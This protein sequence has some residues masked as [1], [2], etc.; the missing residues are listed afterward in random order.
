M[1]QNKSYRIHTEIGKDH[2]VNVPLNQDMS[3][4]EI[5]S[6]KLRQ[7]NVYKLHTSNYG[8]L[9]GRV[10]ANDAFGVQNAKISIFVELDDADKQNS[11]I[12]N[13]YPYTSIST[14]DNNDIRYNLLPDSNNDKCYRVIGTFPNKRLV[15]DDNTE[16]QIFDKYWKF[17]TVTNKSGDY[18][19][20]G[21]PTGQTTVHVDLDISD[22]GVLSQKPHDLLYK[23]Y[24]ISQFDSPTQFKEGTNLNNLTQ[25]F[26]QDSS[27]YVYPFWGDSDVNEI[28]ITR[29]DVQ[30]QYK[31]E[32]T[33]VF[34][35]SLISDS[36]E[37]FV[38]HNCNPS[39]ENG[40]NS[41][42]VASEGTIEMIRKTVDGFVEEYQIQGNRLINGDGVWCYQIPMN[43]DYI[44][45]D[46][47]GN[48]IPVENSS[49]GIP[50]RARVRFRISI[51]E[52]TSTGISRHRAKYLVPNNPKLKDESITLAT[53]NEYNDNLDLE[54]YYRFGTATPE[55]CYRDLYWNKVY[56][57]K[58]YI[59]RLQRSNDIR[60][61]R[62]TGI[63][64]TNYS[65]NI[66]PFPYN[67]I[68]VR[69]PFS[70]RFMCVLSKI[71]IDIIAFLNTTFISVWD[72]LIDLLA[73]GLNFSILGVHPLGWLARL[74]RKL[75]IPCV[76]FPMEDDESSCDNV[77]YAPGCKGAAKDATGDNVDASLNSLGQ[78][79]EQALAQEDEVV[80][81]DFY[82]DWVNG[83]LY[84]PLWFWKK[85]KKKT[86]FFGL[87]SKSAVN[88]YCNCDLNES[89]YL[90]W[91]CTNTRDGNGTSSDNVEYDSH[92]DETH[93]AAINL[94]RGIIKSIN[95]LEGV[96]IYYYS[97]GVEADNYYRLFS[98]DI[99]LLGS[100]NDCDIDGI[101][102]M[103]INLPTTTHNNMPFAREEYNKCSNT[104][105][106][107]SIEA[108]TGMDIWAHDN[109]NQSKASYGNGY[110]LDIGC[111]TIK[112]FTKTCI[113]VERLCELGVSLDME[114]IT[115]NLSSNGYVSGIS[116][117]DGMITR[118]ELVDNDTRAMFATLNHN[119]LN[120]V[121]I[122]KKTGYKKYDLKYLYPTDFDASL[123]NSAKEYTKNLTYQSQDLYNSFYNMFR[124]GTNEG[125][126]S[127]RIYE[128][129]SS[130]F[131]LYNNSYYFY[132][133]VKEGSTALD[134][135]KSQ[136][137]ASCVSNEIKPFTVIPSTSAASTCVYDDNG[138][139]KDENNL[140]SVQ[141]QI[142]G[143]I[144]PY[145]YTITNSGDEILLENI[146][147]SNK[148]LLF[149]HYF[150][151]N[152]D[153]CYNGSG[154]QIPIVNDT[155]TISITDNKGTTVVTEFIVIN[156]SIDLDIQSF[157]LGTR[158]N[159]ISDGQKLCNDNSPYQ[160]GNIKIYGSTIDGKY[161]SITNGSFSGNNG[162]Y[163]LTTVNG[164]IDISITPLPTDT[165]NVAT[166]NDCCCGSN[167]S[168]YYDNIEQCYELDV[169]YPISYNVTATLLCNGVSTNNQSSYV[170]DI[171]NGDIFMMYINDMPFDFVSG[172][173]Y[174]QQ[175][176]SPT[177]YDKWLLMDKISNYTMNNNENDILTN[178]YKWSQWI[179]VDYSAN[180]ATN[181]SGLTKNTIV[182]EVKF[183]LNTL[184]NICNGAYL[185]NN[186]YNS[187]DI[188]YTGGKTPILLQ[189][190]YPMYDSYDNEI[191]NFYNPLRKYQ[192]V[193]NNNTIES[194]ILIPNI[195]ALNYKYYTG[196][197]WT[198]LLKSDSNLSLNLIIDKNK[199][200][201]QGNY[202]S[203]FTNNAGL[204]NCSTIDTSYK[205]HISIP[206]KTDT[207]PF[208]EHCITGVT[209]GLLIDN[210]STITQSSTPYFKTMFVDRRFDYD[211]IVFTSCNDMPGLKYLSSNNQL[212]WKKSKI[213][214]VTY[215]GIELAY[216]SNKNII[217]NS[218]STMSQNNYEY[219]Y[220]LNGS[221]SGCVITT[222]NDINK[223]FY[224]TLLNGID[225][226]NLYQTTENKNTSLSPITINNTTILNCIPKETYS[227]SVVYPKIRTMDL[228]NLPYN[229]GRI[230]FSSTA[231]SYSMECKSDI[232]GNISAATTQGDTIGFSV[233]DGRNITF[234]ADKLTDAAM[235][236]YKYKSDDTPIYSGWVDIHYSYD[237]NGYY[238]PTEIQSFIKIN[239]D[240]GES[241]HTVRSKIPVFLPFDDEAENM[242]YKLKSLDTIKSNVTINGREKNNSIDYILYGGINFTSD[243]WVNKDNVYA[244][245]TVSFLAPK[246]IWV[247]SLY[248]YAVWPAMRY[249]SY[250]SYGE[251]YYYYTNRTT[252]T[253]NMCLIPVDN[254]RSAR[255][256]VNSG[257]CYF[258]DWEY[259]Y[260]VEVVD[261][262][263]GQV[264]NS[265][266]SAIT[267]GIM[268]ST[269]FWRPKNGNVNHNENEGDSQAISLQKNSD[270]TAFYDCFAIIIDSQY[271][272][273]NDNGLTSSIRSINCSNVFDVRKIKLTLISMTDN[274]TDCNFSF[275]LYYGNNTSFLDVNTLSSI[276]YVRRSTASTQND[277][278]AAWS[279]DIN[280]NTDNSITLSG[281]IG[282]CSIAKLREKNAI[283]GLWIKVTGGLKWCL[284][285]KIK[286]DS[287]A[288]DP[289]G[290]NEEFTNISD[291]A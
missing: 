116:Q 110:F 134:K 178:T 69:L 50:T 142:N 174:S 203:M 265:Y 57:V 7:T 247:A 109:S 104:S 88:T 171:D 32:P 135:F 123:K 122:D 229:N 117:S 268:S 170:L 98:T 172:T 75:E 275:K 56:T 93:A 81:L 206:Y 33:C 221:N 71:I 9:V 241:K 43:L 68:R 22:C 188:A 85:A 34:M 249:G 24:T 217:Y 82:N 150:D 48:I 191:N 154:K 95:N 246:M 163:K 227:T 38:G 283:I 51:D 19:I 278:N 121:I 18:C 5:L 143:A 179:G 94:K 201:L 286:S 255:C 152:G 272:N 127:H 139:I 10:L 144:L 138:K 102:Q 224:G 37:I 233:K 161:Q 228:A 215:N 158:I 67:K 54:N 277:I 225:V 23:G 166:I 60:S 20:Y 86:F 287:I 55:E 168:F 72:N 89:T 59:P 232:N 279:C 14:K 29:N 6:L 159:S 83:V 186:G 92:Y 214:G 173:I 73:D 118:N 31:F 239:P 257:K 238:Q 204:T 244:G 254:W 64:T 26:S 119:G 199:N 21:L 149:K 242:L 100:L 145:E 180:T 65:N 218:L 252:E 106:I 245:D 253:T 133:G 269:Y 176:T 259:P 250:N 231:C 175:I 129:D 141:I 66:N 146:S 237:S 61:K 223:K 169:L 63:R 262:S 209:N 260:N 164:I 273:N 196:N 13:I 2:V 151:I 101:P 167:A 267:D 222:S 181:Q 243:N 114:Y 177:N 258:D 261:S 46:E 189:T 44:G 42:L 266:A 17:T 47:Y 153:N 270:A 213:S 156:E 74:V 155:Y 35:G 70:F 192:Y 230:K 87:F 234:A 282:Q 285:F 200:S 30:L 136:F 216:D 157:G 40:Y 212:N 103:F 291:E 58:N 128:T 276:L 76:T 290:F 182:E 183:K 28:A 147:C 284:K 112:L 80:N 220:S 205:E 211:F 96:S 190:F 193:S 137:Y 185:T 25:V 219:S 131:P 251:S 41:Q 240:N 111:N 126:M 11:E 208:S 15:L 289:V 16:L 84:M 263:D 271:D 12:T 3:F 148:I 235:Y 194:N 195:I 53:E 160:E 78:L 274:D 187:F 91:P 288:I 207:H 198:H 130:N 197:Y 256:V 202:I 1:S 99:V 120:K 8:V 210:A 280:S 49:K 184:F 140:G 36:Q 27:V 236:A 115:N 108:I 62:Y 132:F 248:F 77:I 125:E 113:N 264:L 45:T 226:N 52:S 79:I 105:S 107:P 97:S 281:T 165:F 162:K 90:V 4:L 39:T 124:Y